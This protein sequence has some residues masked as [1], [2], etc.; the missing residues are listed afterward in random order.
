MDTLQRVAG[1]GDASDDSAARLG[2]ARLTAAAGVPTAPPA[3]A[4]APPS[5]QVVTPTTQ[6]RDRGVAGNGHARA[7]GGRDP[8]P[9]LTPDSAPAAVINW[10]HHYGFADDVVQH[11]SRYDGED[12]FELCVAR[13]C[14]A[15]LV[16]VCV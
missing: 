12:M 8:A 7:A 1:N 15:L 2:A 14:W 6:S 3:A 16:V 4:G 5:A 11:L 13:L 9:S 10:L